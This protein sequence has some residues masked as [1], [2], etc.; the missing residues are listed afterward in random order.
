M[1]LPSGRAGRGHDNDGAGILQRKALGDE[2]VLPADAAHHLAILQRVRHD[3]AEQRRHHGVVDEPRLHPR[4]ALGCF[5]A[6]ELV[7]NDIAV[8]RSRARSASG[9]SRSAR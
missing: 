2:I 9:I 7:V 8:I 4:P 5:V 6:V 3:G 1:V